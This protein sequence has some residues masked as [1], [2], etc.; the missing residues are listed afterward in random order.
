MH[1]D[2]AGVHALPLS[3][4]FGETE[5]TIT[6]AAVETR[7]GLLLI[8]V[9]LPGAVDGIETHVST[10]GYD[11]DDVH[12]VLLT[13]HDGDHAGGLAELLERVDAT[14]AAHPEEA[15]YVAGDR[16]PIKS[17]GDRYPP[18]PVDLELVGGVR[19]STA[20][21][22]MELVETPGH[23]PGHLSLYFPHE[24]LLLAADALNADGDRALSGPKPEYTPEMG[25]AIESVRRLADLDVE[26]TLCYHGG[27]AEAGTDRIREIHAAFSD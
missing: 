3:F 9:G 14:V 18:A 12:T 16:E 20:A 11:L 8:D 2:D 7:R 13:H 22:P 15:P 27:Y 25:R 6:P 26:H 4:E 10:L 21:G 17:E 24:K 1:A 5:L 23:S 19:F